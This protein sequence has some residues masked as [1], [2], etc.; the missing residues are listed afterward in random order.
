MSAGS[1]CWQKDVRSKGSP[2]QYGVVVRLVQMAYCIRVS[3]V[4]V[5]FQKSESQKH[6]ELWKIIIFTVMC[7]VMK[8]AGKENGQ[9]R[10]T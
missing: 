5:C 6:E 2:Q 8:W 10:A 4:T 9:K 1:Q 7:M 3:L